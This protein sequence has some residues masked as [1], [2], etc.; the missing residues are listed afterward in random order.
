MGQEIR[1]TNFSQSV[2][3]EFRARLRRE[4]ATLKGWFEQK[5]FDCDSAFTVGLELEGWL[6]DENHL[7]TPRN[8]EFF[9][10]AND[11]DIVPELSKFNFEINAPPQRLDG[12]CFSLTHKDI[13]T[14]WNKCRRAADMLNIKPVAIGIMPTVRDEMLQ[15][16][17]MS[18]SNRY[19]AMNRELFAR[20]KNVPLHIDIEGDDYLDYRCDHLMLEAACTSL[21]AHLKINQ[22]NAVRLYNAAILA[23]AP[24]L[25]ASVNSPYLYGKSLWDET[26]IAAFEQ[27][28]ASDS[29]RDRN[30]RNVQRVT[31]GMGYLR[32]SMME[33]FLENLSYPSLLP[34]LQDDVSTLPHLQMQ[35]GT[36]W[37][38]VRPILGF[39]KSDAPHLRIEHRVMPAG[40]SLPDT[41]ANLALCHGLVLGL[42]G[43][44]AP[45]EGRTPFQDARAN[46]YACAKKGLHASVRW[47]GKMVKVQTLLLNRLLPLA[48]QALEVKGVSGT[49]LD[50]Y[51]EEILKPRIRGG[52]TGAQWQRNYVAAN[53]SN[54]Q[55]LTEAYVRNQ[56]LG[57]PVHEWT[58]GPG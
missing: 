58:T 20:R 21:Q 56:S 7:P 48:K 1:D 3:E 26:R 19:Q 17:W 2:R 8:V 11:P 49:D 28:T 34:A 57:H 22:D 4:T 43:L 12:D 33:L 31:M 41:V 44:E 53:G 40:P 27:A 29:F 9:S 14:R 38:W 16:S 5:A 25:A 13:E 23:A 6:I 50:F 54:F 42:G 46:F 35:N 30:G 32:R 10:T 47:E 15:P 24:L 52:Q 55:A 51:F 37:R 45:P 39:D 36:I 18:E